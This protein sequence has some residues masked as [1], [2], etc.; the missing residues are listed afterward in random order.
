MSGALRAL[1][2]EPVIHFVLIGALLFA[3]DAV[4]SPAETGDDARHPFAVPQGPIVVDE[5]VRSLL[6]EQWQRTH[7]APPTEA[8]LR[9]LVE[10]WIDDEVLYREGLARGLAEDDPRV[11]ERVASQMAYVLES[12]ITIP[13]PSEDELR[14]WLDANAARYASPTRVDFTQV[15]VDGLD[16]AAE[17]RAREILGLLAGGADPSG[18]GDTFSGG[19]RF[20]GR[21]LDDLAERFGDAFITDMPTQPVGTWALRRSTLGLHLVR[22]DHRTA[23]ET[24]SF[25][26]LRERLL[27]DWQ[28]AQRE[29]AMTEAKRALREQW[30]I[31]PAP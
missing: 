23:S 21:K 14:T 16:A 25:E 7:P 27:H 1:V 11:R 5:A 17:A 12:R 3:L 29:A 26:A 22:I 18:L 2:R 15:F 8:E 9:P 10:A 20:R 28:A 6:V 30:E 31:Q 4:V 24:P 13:T 19:R